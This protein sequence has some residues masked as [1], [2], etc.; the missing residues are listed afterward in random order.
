MTKGTRKLIWGLVGLA[1]FGMVAAAQAE[2]LTA[3]LVSEVPPTI[4]KGTGLAT[5]T[6]DKA[7]EIPTW[8]VTYDDLSG[9]A[10]ARHFH[11]PAAAGA[12]ADVVVPL[13]IIGRGPRAT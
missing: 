6:L 11:G 9:D 5:A 10:T 8:T 7:T 1:S 4:W 13:T 2:N 3:K 12:N